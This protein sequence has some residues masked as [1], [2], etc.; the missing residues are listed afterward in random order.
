MG[1]ARGI[2]RNLTHHAASVCA[3]EARLYVR[4]A[5]RPVMSVK[6]RGS[7]GVSFT[8]AAYARKTERS[9]TILRRISASVG[10]GAPREGTVGAWCGWGNREVIAGCRGLSHRLSFLFPPRSARTHAS[11]TTRHSRKSASAHPLIA[12]HRGILPLVL[13]T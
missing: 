13:L 9:R 12:T 5:L 4:G 10:P 8:H 7:E 6:E 2:V 1:L 11:R 3:R